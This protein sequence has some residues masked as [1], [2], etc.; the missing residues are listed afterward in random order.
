[1]NGISVSRLRPDG[2]EWVAVA[3]KTGKNVVKGTL[4]LIIG[5]LIVKIIGALFKLPL[6]NIVGADGMGL[7]NA[8][9]IVF[10]IF[11]VLATAGFPMAISKMVANSAARGE[12]GESIKIFRVARNCFIL[13]GAVFSTIMFFGA[14]LFSQ[15]IGNTRSFLCIL[16]LAPAVLFVSVMSAY[17]GYYQGT[18]DMIPTTVSQII[19]AVCRLVVGLS[20]SWYLK[21]RGFDMPVVAAGAMVGITVGEFSSTFALAMIHHR[22]RRKLP[23]P[24]KCRVPASQI[25]ST[26]FETSIPIGIGTIV[27]SVINMLD[28]AVV[29][30]RLQFI[31]YTETQAN[32]LYGTYNMAFAVF[33]LPVTIVS[34]L[35]TSVFPLFSY[36]WARRSYSRV[37]RAVQA[38]LR[39][40]MI[41][42][43]GSAAFFVSLSA[44]VINLLYFNQPAAAKVASPLLM[45]LSPASVMISL[46]MI[47]SS[48]LFATDHMIFPTCT[49]IAGG[50][51]CLVSNWFLVG[52][53]NLGIFGAPAGIFICYTITAVLNLWKIKRIDVLHVRFRNLFY[54]PFVPSAVM[55]ITGAVAFRLTES[56]FGLLKSSCFSL[57]LSLINFILVLFLNNTISG[58]DLLLL[59][60]GRKLAVVLEKLHL[61]APRAESTD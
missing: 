49:M 40:T 43:M 41:V 15:L 8:S 36:T 29:M 46:T 5:N 11:L 47:S 42:A 7:Y 39:I 4:V 17:R 56:S 12:S 21:S 20:L 52:S 34:A 33:S 10:D 1:M 54:K 9:F 60:G 30:H 2:W 32:T 26:M 25:I 31:G 38:S 50:T 18:N 24:K 48:I 27:I 13:I 23:R 53:R 35:Q 61:I 3:K 59:P 6:A 55:A 44:P 57:L 45:L 22:R 58:D 37:S 51:A 14:R 16:V 19:E 28:N